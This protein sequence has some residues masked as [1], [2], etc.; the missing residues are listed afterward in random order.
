MPEV[1]VIDA[2]E[3]A[4]EYIAENMRP[5]DAY[6]ARAMGCEPHIAIERSW[7]ASTMATMMAVDGVPALVLGVVPR[8]ELTGLGVP[9]L[10]GTE[11]TSRIP[12]WFVRDS[13]SYIDLFLTRYD[14]LR[15]LVATENEQS[16][17]WL[18]WMGATFGAPFPAGLRGEMF[19]PFWIRKH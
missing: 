13:V 1:T 3:E 16:I 11:D 15:N 6:E 5:M 14:M 9:W 7:N 12:R 4:A 10:L 17:R 8:S 2:T 18:T 19:L